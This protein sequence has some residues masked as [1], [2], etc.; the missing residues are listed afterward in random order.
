MTEFT[1]NSC[2]PRT[3]LSHMALYGFAAILEAEG[4]T[5]ARVRWTGDRA[6]PR[7]VVSF[8]GLDEISVAALLHRHAQA[9]NAEDAWVQQNIVLKTANG[10]S[11]RGLMSP[12]LAAFAD[13]GLWKR[14][15]RQRHG[16]LDS[17]TSGHRWLDLKFV[18]A[19]GE[20][21]YWRFNSKDA[22]LQDDGASRYEMQPRNQGAE[23]V[24]SRLRKLAEAVARRDP[25][26]LLAGLRGESVKDEI[27]S[28]RSDSRTATGLAGLG[29][30]D[31]ALAW[32]ALWGISQLPTAMR[33]NS[34]ADTTGHLGFRRN[35]WFYAPIWHEPWRPARLRSVLA[36]RPLR[37]LASDGIKE[38]VAGV[39]RKPFA[40]TDISEA[41]A[42]LGSRGVEGVMRFPIQKFGSANAPERRAMDGEPIPVLTFA[43]ADT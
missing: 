2:E 21:C 28:D 39:E 22:P 15:Q 9:L 29:P 17:L 35:E 7:P 18:A 26:E 33:V 41:R 42:W 27:G 1:L 43:R 34:P 5:D 4:A 6:K 32:C 24:G 36:S 3:L 37:V 19:L 14:V 25:S 40:D 31:N 16:V 23:F 11:A 30:T 10:E 13:P 20:P 38:T 8:P 12:R